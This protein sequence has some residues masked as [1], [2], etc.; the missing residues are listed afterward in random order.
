M[1]HT[2]GRPPTSSCR[3]HEPGAMT[4]LSL[5]PDRCLDDCLACW[6]RSAERSCRGD[7]R[8]VEQW[9]ADQGVEAEVVTD[10]VQDRGA[11][12]DCEVLGN[13]IDG[14]RLIVDDLVLCCGC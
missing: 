4:S 8:E 5:V 6:L 7:L 13:A 1:R 12:C 9:C 2:C 3:S 10:F 14:S 11:Y